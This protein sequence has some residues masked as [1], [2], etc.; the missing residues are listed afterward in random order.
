[1]ATRI[2][3]AMRFADVKAML[4]GEPVEHGTTTDDAIAFIDAEMALLAKKNTGERKPSKTAMDNENVYK[5]LVYSYL[6]SKPDGATCAE[7]LDGIPEL[8]NEHYGTQK[9]TPL[10]KTLMAE[11]KV[12]RDVRKGRAYWSIA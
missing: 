7:I 6:S 9:I 12:K 5:P 1:M 11:G 10:V 3:K 8:K 4:M 2:T